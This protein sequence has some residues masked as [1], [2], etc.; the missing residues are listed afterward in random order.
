ML[1]LLSGIL[2]AAASGSK[3]GSRPDITEPTL[4]RF[5]ALAGFAFVLV[6]ASGVINSSIRLTSWND[7]FGS[8]YGQLILAK[9]A[10]TLVLGGIGLMHRQLGH[11]AAGQPGRRPVRP[12]RALAARRRRNC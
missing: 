2:G 5:S 3:S 12:P 1:A 4:R 7:L 11:P 8:A 6:F 9:A 10:A